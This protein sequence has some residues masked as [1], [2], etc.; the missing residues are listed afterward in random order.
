[1]LDVT[2]SGRGQLLPESQVGGDTPA[3]DC[4]HQ[5]QFLPP[6]QLHQLLGLLQVHAER[7]LAQ[8]VLARLQVDPGQGEVTGVDGTHVDHVNIRVARQAGVVAVSL[9]NPVFTSELLGIFQ[10]PSG[11]RH[12]LKMHQRIYYWI[13]GNKITLWSGSTPT[14]ALV[15][16]WEIRPALAMPHLVI[17]SCQQNSLF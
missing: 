8:H 16:S 5:E 2:H 12:N 13:V 15:K 11:H 14:I 1:M 7:L 17:M 6:R 4:L 9:G 10:L 3:P